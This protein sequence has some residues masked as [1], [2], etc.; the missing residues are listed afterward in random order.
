[1]PSTPFTG[2]AS[3][4]S[5]MNNFVALGAYATSLLVISFEAMDGRELRLWQAT[6]VRRSHE[7]A[8]RFVVPSLWCHL[9]GG[10]TL[11]KATWPESTVSPVVKLAFAMSGVSSVLVRVDMSVGETGVIA[12]TKDDNNFS[13][14]ILVK[15]DCYI[16]T[17]MRIKDGVAWRRV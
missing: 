16:R 15:Q 14:P 10:G 3:T 17:C 1:M 5:A 11:T 2:G 12:A 7:L 4:P 6:A 13:E 8:E 9:G